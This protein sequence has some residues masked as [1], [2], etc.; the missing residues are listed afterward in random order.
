[1]N[2]S[3]NIQEFSSQLNDDEF[4][5]EVETEDEELDDETGEE[6]IDETEEEDDKADEETDDEFLMPEKFKGKSPQ[7]IAKAY[8]ELEKLVERKAQEKAEAL[9]KE[10]SKPFKEE[11]KKEYPMTPHGMPDFSKFTPEQFA[12]WMM[13]EVDKRAEEKAKKI[14]QSS[15]EMRAEVRKT[16]A[17]VRK[18]HPLLK[19]NKE[20]TDLV[21]ALIESSSA[22]G[23]QIN[24]KEAC[25]KVDKL[26]GEK[27]K[28]AKKDTDKLKKTRLAVEKTSGAS[29]GKQKTEEELIKESLMGG[30]K[31]S[32]LGGL[33]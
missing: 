5:E 9:A 20:Y 16:I 14:Y 31:S 28:L 6:D 33:G 10:K 15:D 23:E 4:D 3:D 19:E 25:E 17:N 30:K 24:I 11:P 8:S 26:L 1:M 27:I 21:L 32:V 18:D 22:R 13:G 12:E 2:T 29:G 7:E